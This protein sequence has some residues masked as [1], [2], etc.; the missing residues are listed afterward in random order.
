VEIKARAQTRMRMRR[1][2]QRAEAAMK[3]LGF[4][5]PELIA[6]GADKQWRR[7]TSVAELGEAGR[8]M[9][10]CTSWDRPQSGNYANM[11]I[12]GDAEFWILETKDGGEA[13]MEV[14]A[15]TAQKT[16]LEFLGPGNRAVDPSSPELAALMRAKGFVFK[17][18]RKTPAPQA[19]IVDLR[20]VLRRELNAELDRSG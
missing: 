10:N 14:M 9:R 15:S 11:L 12:E 18:A 1:E 2:K 4:C 7:L 19:L 3:T 20:A 13:L 8:R 17:R 6:V 5:E 16:L